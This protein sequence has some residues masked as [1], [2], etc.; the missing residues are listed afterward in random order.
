MFALK[1]LIKNCCPL[2]LAFILM[3]MM[4]V[5]GLSANAQQPIGGHFTMSKPVT[6]RYTSYN[7]YNAG[8]STQNVRRPYFKNGNVVQQGYYGLPA[9][10]RYQNAV[11]PRR[12]RS[13]RRYN[14]RSPR[15]RVYNRV[16]TMYGNP[17]II[18]TQRSYPLGQRNVSITGGRF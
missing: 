3:I 2:V 10:I 9:N 13:K 12:T 17:A 8:I 14:R 15:G 5:F 4:G 18:N 6:A 16:N 1:H 11:T 7:G